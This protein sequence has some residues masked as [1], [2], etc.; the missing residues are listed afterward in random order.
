MAEKQC[1]IMLELLTGLGNMLFKNENNVSIA[2][3]MDIGATCDDV[4]V[5]GGEEE[6][7]N[8]IKELKVFLVKI[9]K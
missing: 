6:D 1:N 5:E 3:D 2:K 4:K 7:L 8:D 9:L